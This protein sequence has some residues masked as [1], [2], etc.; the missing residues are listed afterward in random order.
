M[1][2]CCSIIVIVLLVAACDM[3][4]NSKQAPEKVS[5]SKEDSLKILGEID[6]FKPE[7]HDSSMELIFGKPKYDISAIGILVYYSPLHLQLIFDVPWTI[8]PGLFLFQNIQVMKKAVLSLLLALVYLSCEKSSRL[9]DAPDQRPPLL[10]KL[11]GHWRMTGQVMG[12]SV[13]YALHVQPVLNATF[14]E[15]HMVDVAN[16]PQY[17]A[18]VY[19][20]YDTTGRQILAHWLDSF[21]PGYSIPHGVGYLSG[22][23]IVFTIPY[24][25][26]PFRDMLAYRPDS[27]S[28]SFII[29]SSKDSMTWSNFAAYALY[30]KN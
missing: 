23:S 15:L 20:G 25:D 12:D 7:N 18:R 19:I 3:R 8:L 22:D 16:P 9:Q 13:E 17:E 6:H 11:D 24:K 30:R 27:D 28:W 26:G 29:D 2:K 5:V 10:Q 1:K 14:S 21:G 4:Q